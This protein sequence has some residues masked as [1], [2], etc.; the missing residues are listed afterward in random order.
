MYENRCKVCGF[1]WQSETK[2]KKC[3]S[4]GQEELRSIDSSYTESDKSNEPIIGK[5][6]PKSNS[7]DSLKESTIPGKIADSNLDVGGEA[8]GS[9]E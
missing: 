6:N 4:C 5:D 3:T 8:S 7:Q 2:P 1:I 9:I